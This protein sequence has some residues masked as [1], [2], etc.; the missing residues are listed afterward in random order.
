MNTA[1]ML[2]MKPQSHDKYPYPHLTC[3]YL[4]STVPIP[5]QLTTHNYFPVSLV[6]F[7]STFLSMLILLFIHLPILD[8][9]I[10]VV[11]M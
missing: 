7:I 2:I 10:F 11:F 8:L 3:T 1:K 9:F 5:D 6:F 4:P